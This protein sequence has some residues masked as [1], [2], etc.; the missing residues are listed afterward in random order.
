MN[1]KLL[2]SYQHIFEDQLL[3]EID[4]TGR[5][6]TIAQGSVMM[7]IN[8]NIAFMP[9]V[10]NGAIRVMNEDEE[11]NEFLL[12][13]LEVGD[14]CSMTMT[15][16]LGDK[17]SK[18]RAV[19]EKETEICMIPIHMMEEWLIKYKT[20]RK[21]VFD[22]Y[23]IRLKE[24]LEA[25][26]TVVFHNMEERLYKYLKDRAM[27]LGTNDLEITHHQ[28]ANDLNTSRV[29]ISRLIKKLQLTGQISSHRNKI[30]LIKIASFK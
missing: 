8:D 9:L 26:N 23:D 25:I 11:G 7:N 16:C 30:S 20:W 3:Q 1:S 24:M 4:K 17:K 18:I 19:A 14:S 28:I 5:Y 6:K 22:S 12:Y 27:V 2:L 13:Y 10:M 21:F 29:V 15:C